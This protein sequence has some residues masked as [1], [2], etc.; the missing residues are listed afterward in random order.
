MPVAESERPVFLGRRFAAM[1]HRGGWVDPA[2]QPRENTRYAFGRALA[3]GFEFLETDVW[4][5]ADDQLVAFHDDRLDRVTDGKGL[6]SEH[7]W[8]GLEGVRI[9]G[10]DPIPRLVDLL[11]EFDAARFNIDIKD[12]R[13]V[14]PLADVIARCGAENRVC[15]A[16]FSTARLKQFRRLA[17]GVPTAVSPAGVAVATHGF[18]LRRLLPDAGKAL[19]VPVRHGGVPLTLIRPDVIRLAHAAGRVIHVWTVN[20]EAEMHR[21]LD[22]GVDGIVSDDI[23]TLKRVLVG[24]GLWEGES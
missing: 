10:L 21:L 5:T 2:D 6:V 3:Q 12:D 14:R 4:A 8:A 17:P 23:T 16:S 7:T 24:R 13:A 15:V 9:G 20:E 19:Q 18:G 11:E 1:A 22:L